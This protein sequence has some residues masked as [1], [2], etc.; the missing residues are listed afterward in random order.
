MAN[1]NPIPVVPREPASIPILETSVPGRPQETL[2]MVVLDVTEYDVWH[3]RA[4][5]ES[6]TVE[7]QHHTGTTIFIVVSKQ[8]VL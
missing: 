3:R 5:S 4:V 2:S 1:E 6:Q 8:R 7:C